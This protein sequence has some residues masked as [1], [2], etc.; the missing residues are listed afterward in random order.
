MR[1]HVLA[2]A[3]YGEMPGM[4]QL[5]GGKGKQTALQQRDLRLCNEFENKIDGTLKKFENFS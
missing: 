5:Y 4:R 1:F 3:I 2:E